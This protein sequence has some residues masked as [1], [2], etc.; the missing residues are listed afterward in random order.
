VCGQKQGE[1]GLDATIDLVEYEMEK[2]FRKEI[3]L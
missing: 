1:V 3:G 2:R